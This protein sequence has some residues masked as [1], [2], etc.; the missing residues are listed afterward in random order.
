MRFLF[1]IGQSPFDP[2]SGAAQ[3]TLHLGLI[4]ARAGHQVSILATSGTEG[5]GGANLPEGR[6]IRDGIQFCILQV[7]ASQKHSW[8]LLVGDQYEREFGRMLGAEQVDWL[9][10]F[11]DEEPDRCRRS[12]A[13]ECG[14]RVLFA[15][16]NEFYRARKPECVDRFLAPSH[17]L[18]ARY[19]DAWGA[20]CEISVVPTP[21]LPERV[22][23]KNREPIFAV[24]V[25]PHPSKG[26]YFL[27]RLAD[28]L[29]RQR[30]DLPLQIVGGRSTASFLT[31]AAGRLGVDLGQYENLYFA[32][33]Y[34]DVRHLWQTARVLLM[35]SVWQEPAGRL[36]VEAA[37]NGVVPLVSNRGGLPEQLEGG[38]TP[39]PLPEWMRP[40]SVALPSPDEVAPW[41]AILKRCFDEE[42]FYQATSGRVR[43]LAEEKWGPRQIQAYEELFR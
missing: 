41:L 30:P 16:H 38:V 36:P 42:D 2:T 18:A 4:L 6:F 15:L 23:A 19:R 43:S 33:S 14:V 12:L 26:L 11:G 24:F 5:V 8:H 1:A 9:I 37:L 28:E 40:E 25:N 39:L 17:F 31:A 7:P 10:T 22:V 35:P 21:L 29:G 27:I 20:H 3:A 32:E 34:P 13:Q